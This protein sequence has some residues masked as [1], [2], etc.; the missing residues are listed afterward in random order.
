MRPRF[1]SVLTVTALLAAAASL[2]ES[3]VNLGAT[4]NPRHLLGFEIPTSLAMAIGW[5]LAVA[6]PG[7]Y[8]ATA[9]GL[10]RLRPWARVVA[11][12]YLAWVIVSFLFFGVAATDGR[13]ATAVMLWQIS[14]V[15]F[16]TFCFMFLYNGARYFTATER[17]VSLP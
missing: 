4:A 5:I 7:A 11:M 16:A 10:W 3:A 1:V 9:V 12:A 13:R 2:A 6:E 8:L 14:V 15:P 17:R